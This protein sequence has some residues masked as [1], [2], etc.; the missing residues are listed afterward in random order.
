MEQSSLGNALLVDDAPTTASPLPGNWSTGEESEGKIKH[1]GVLRV[2]FFTA[3]T[4]LPDELELLEDIYF[5]AMSSDTYLQEIG[6]INIFTEE[7]SFT[8]K[9]EYIVAIKYGEI[10]GD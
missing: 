2:K 4:S 8:K 3:N 7:T 6:D 5:K 9:G 10:T 1:K